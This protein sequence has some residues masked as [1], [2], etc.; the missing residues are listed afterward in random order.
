M[1]A[2]FNAMDVIGDKLIQFADPERE[3]T[4][5]TKVRGS[6]LVSH[7]IFLMNNETFALNQKLIGYNN[8]WDDAMIPII[9]ISQ[10]SSIRP[11]LNHSFHLYRDGLS[12]TSVPQVLSLSHTSRL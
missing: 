9:C 6:L 2:Y 4:G 3:F 8:Q 10:K 5:Y 11:N 7:V 1:E 12:L